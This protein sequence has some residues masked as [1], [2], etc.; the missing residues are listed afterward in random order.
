MRKVFQHPL[1]SYITADYDVSVLELRRTLEFNENIRPISLA[2]ELP[3]P[4][5][6]A[7]AAGW[8]VTK[9][10]G[11]STSNTLKAVQI[12]IVDH[13]KCRNNY[14]RRGRSFTVT[15]RMICAGYDKGGKNICSGDSG[16]SLS[17]GDEIYGISSWSVG[18]ALPNRP[19]VFTSVPSVMD[20][21]NSTMES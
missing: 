8:G 6:M 14:R 20:F 10:H 16:G 3:E 19:A 9:S 21:I 12:P 11:T 18:C 7:D 2:S 1:F 15:D 4:G 5:T 17:I 13:E